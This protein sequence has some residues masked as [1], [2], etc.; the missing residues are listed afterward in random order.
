MNCSVCN[1]CL[2]A[3]IITTLLL[4]MCLFLNTTNWKVGPIQDCSKTTD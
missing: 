3:I 4:T 1:E 2:F